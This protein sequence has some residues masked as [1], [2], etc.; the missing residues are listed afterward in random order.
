MLHYNVTIGKVTLKQ[1]NDDPTEYTDIDD[2]SDFTLIVDNVVANVTFTLNAYEKTLRDKVLGDTGITY[3][4]SDRK[5]SDDYTLHDSNVIS[6]V[7]EGDTIDLFGKTVKVLDIGSDYIEYGNDWGETYIDAGTSKTFGD[8]SIKVLD[9]DVNQEKALLEVS[10]P[11]GSEK[12]TLNADDN[13]TETLFNGGIRVT[14]TDTFIGIGGT[15]SVKVEVQTDISKIKDGKEFIPGWIAHLGIDDGKLNWFAL[16][17]KKELEGKEVKLFDTYVMDYRADIMKKKNPSDDKTYAAMEAWVVIDPLKPEYTTKT[18]SAGDTLEGW[19]IDEIT[20]TADPAQ[21]AVVSKITTPITVLDTEVMEQG[22]DKVDSNLILIGGPVVN[23]VTAALAEKLEVPSDYNGW[24]EEYGTG[25]DSGVVK[26]IAECGDIN[27]YGVVLVAGTDRE[28]TA[29]AA[30][31]L[32]E[33]LAG[34]S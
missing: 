28:G 10:G 25:A 27:G 33:Y 3:T 21:A 15:S 22:L 5:P 2:F 11:A 9:I 32:M 16:T 6:G 31:A 13:P 7:E 4:V 29:A 23:S 1:L 14:L 8:Y 34:L 18:L 26:Y 17:N 30:K 12:I 20:A 19:T 24:K